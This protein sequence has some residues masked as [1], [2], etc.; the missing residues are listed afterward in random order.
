MEE[1]NWTNACTH[2]QHTNTHNICSFSSVQ[3]F[4]E[5]KKGKEAV[6]EERA[7]RADVIVQERAVG[8]HVVV[9]E[10]AVGAD[11]VA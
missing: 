4:V 1:Q 9:E 10:R 11:V 2:K 7:V 8:P 5:G 6:V 3:N